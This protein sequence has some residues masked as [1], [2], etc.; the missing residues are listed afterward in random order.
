MPSPLPRNAP[1]A[2]PKHRPVAA[3]SLREGQKDETRRDELPFSF[4]G[5]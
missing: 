4:L 3:G 1:A 2:P 5:R